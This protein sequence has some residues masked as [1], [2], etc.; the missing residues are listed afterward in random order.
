MYIGVKH[1]DRCI[2]TAK[3][4]QTNAH[5]QGREHKNTLIT[6]PAPQIDRVDDYQVCYYFFYTLSYT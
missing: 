2:T 4:L 3:R 6:C 1:H 5:N